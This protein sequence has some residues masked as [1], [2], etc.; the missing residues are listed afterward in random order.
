LAVFKLCAMEAESKVKI[1]EES[2]QR[3]FLAKKKQNR[4]L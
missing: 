1:I 4:A 3:T 2:A